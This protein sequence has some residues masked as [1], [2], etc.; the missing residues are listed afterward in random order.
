MKMQKKVKSIQV[1][2]KPVDRAL[3]GDRCGVCLANFDSKA[4]ERGM[5]CS[6]GYLK[7]AYAVIVKLNRIRYYKGTIESGA[8]FHV[9]IGH[10]TLLGRVELFEGADLRPPT[11]SIDSHTPFNFNDDYLHV[12]EQSVDDAAALA[13]RDRVLYALIDF[14]HE[15]TGGGVDVSTSGGVLCVEDSLLI[16]SKLDTDINLNQCRIAFYG[17]VC[18]QFTNRD[19][20]DLHAKASLSSSSTSTP[21]SVVAGS[22]T[23]LADL[24]VYKMKSKEGAVDRKHD[25][26]TVIGRSLFK[27]ETNIEMFVGLKVHLSTG[28]VG[29]IEGGFGQSGKFKVRIPGE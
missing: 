6:P 9:T 29:I 27:K 16:G 7:Y 14:S 3:A 10:D 1:F 19:F 22:G 25:E 20:K 5:V 12:S 15:A 17:R 24:R 23:S 11:S 4:F 8:R 13:K 21:A 28:E 2:R 26:Q 18:H